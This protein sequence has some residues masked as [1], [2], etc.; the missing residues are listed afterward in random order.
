M[1]SSRFNALLCA[2]GSSRKG[3]AEAVRY[4]KQ[5]QSRLAKKRGCSNAYNNE[6]DSNLN[7]TGVLHGLL[8]LSMYSNTYMQIKDLFSI[9]IPHRYETL[10]QQP[11]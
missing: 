3:Q 6:D 5:T 7:M 4:K 2:Y 1:L 8:I 9:A 11:H 10:I